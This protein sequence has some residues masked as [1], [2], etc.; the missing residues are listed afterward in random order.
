MASVAPGLQAVSSDFDG[1]FHAGS[2]PLT[3][4]VFF[5]QAQHLE[6][7]ESTVWA[8][9]QANRGTTGTSTGVAGSCDN[10]ARR[11]L[12]DDEMSHV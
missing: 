10:P 2:T 11:G 7:P 4:M 5:T 1:G 6:T 9:S 12:W 8:L 3:S